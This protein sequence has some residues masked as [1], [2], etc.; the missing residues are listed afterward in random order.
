MISIVIPTYNE[1]D[2]ITELVGRLEKTLTGIPHEI[3]FVDDDSPD[4]T[5]ER[6]RNMKRKN[7]KV[8][9]RTNTRGLTGAVV[10]GVKNAKGEVIVVMDADLSHPPEKIPEM[11]RKIEEGHD[12]VVASRLM[13]GGG[14]ID[15]PIQR[16]IISI[17][18]TLIAKTIL[19]IRCS[20]PMSGFFVIRKK[21]FERTQ[22]RIKG[23]KILLN[24]LKD[25][26]AAKI[27]EIPYVFENRHKGK[28]KLGF[29]ETMQYVMDV[30]H[31]LIS[32]K[33]QMS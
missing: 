26:P 21:I 2:N 27:Y 7:V 23:Y 5:V 15:W 30:L 25:N 31:L 33:Q 17:G 11:I 10:E 4:G 29:G 20:D 19:G 16:R 6:I 1:K 14:V 3:I 28:T 9:V 13:Q 18:A 22:F 12:I 24:I 8:I 32:P